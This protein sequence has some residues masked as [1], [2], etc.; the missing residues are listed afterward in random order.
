MVLAE[1][2]EDFKKVN[3]VTPDLLMAQGVLHFI[4]GRYQEAVDTFQEAVHID[5]ENYGSWNKFGAA[6][7]RLGHDDLAKNAYRNALDLKPNYLRTWSN[8][9]H[10]YRADVSP[11]F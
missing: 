8:L 7:A 3:G 4:G 1:K 11:E 6:L 2:F 5:P 10:N 9:G